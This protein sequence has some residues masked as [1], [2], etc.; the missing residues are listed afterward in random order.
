[1]IEAISLTKKFD[2]VTA[3]QD[4]SFQVSK[5]E[6]VGLLGPN[7][8]GKTTT[9]RMLTGYYEPTSGTVKIG[10]MDIRQNR[11]EVQ[12][13]IGYLPESSS[14]YLDMLVCDF[15][16]FV[17][18]A[19]DLSP[20]DKKR[21]IEYAVAAAGLEGYYYRPIHELSKGYR[22]RVGLA[23]SLVHDP[24]VLILDEPTSGLDPNQIAEIQELLRKLASEKTVLLST[25][26][27]SEVEAVC[28]RAIIISQGKIVF[29]DHI[30]RAGQQSGHVVARLQGDGVSAKTVA[31]FLGIAEGDI[32][33]TTE[34]A[35]Y[36]LR[37]A[38]TQFDTVRLYELCVKE[39]WRLAELYYERRS[40]AEIFRT[41][42]G[43]HV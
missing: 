3:V 17:A 25:H 29:D 24:E 36:K 20:A 30:A 22:Q 10:G 2:I 38:N 37:I 1:M 42:T 40:F 5:G 13:L 7:G 4:V 18:D 31:N 19:R 28:S 33:I 6:A 12:Q 11:R 15:L 41:L 14:S 39:G 16:N 32:Q 9:M 35:W 8:A 23:A 43:G 21:G 34:E 26:I 27:L